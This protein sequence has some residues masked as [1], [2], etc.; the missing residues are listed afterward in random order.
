MN[1]LTEVCLLHNELFSPLLG[2]T[3]TQALMHEAKRA[4]AHL[5][6]HEHAKLHFLSLR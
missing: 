1:I 5:H 2:A 4:Y 6:T 3:Y